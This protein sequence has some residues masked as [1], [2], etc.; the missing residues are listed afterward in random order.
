MLVLLLVANA[1]LFSLWPWRRE[2]APAADATDPLFIAR[3]DGTYSLNFPSVLRNR[4]FMKQFFEQVRAERRVLFLGTSE[5]IAPH[6]IGSQLNALRP[7]A[8]R[9]VVTAK[10]G[11]SPIH[12]CLALAQAKDRG[13]PI[14]PLILIVNLVYFTHSHDVID[15]GW[16][17][18][19]T[20][21]EEFLYLNHANRLAH[22]LPEAQQAFRAHFLFRFPLYPMWVQKYLGY[23]LFLHFHGLVPENLTALDL[24]TPAYRFDGK[25][26]TYDEARGV[27][28]G[29]IAADQWATAR[30][31]VSDADES[32]NLRGI[33]SSLAM[34]KDAGAPVLVVILPTN[35]RFYEY[36]P[37]ISRV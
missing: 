17:S 20:R 27:G 24:P 34:L 11:L 4:A 31:T 5:S 22:L 37:H 12:R 2:L 25:I 10:A 32:V 16:L 28:A 15:D 8:P 21:T 13:I 7:E 1:L 14:P 6:N 30:W 23:I 19:V 18:S 35:R 29:Y 26:P 36:N 33:A 9:L 3:P